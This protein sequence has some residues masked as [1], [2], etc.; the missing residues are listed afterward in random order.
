MK[1]FLAALAVLFALP[2]HAGI[3]TGR[4]G[5]FAT[6]EYSGADIECFNEAKFNAWIAEN[7]ADFLMVTRIPDQTHPDLGAVHIGIVANGKTP[8]EA[9][10]YYIMAYALSTAE[11]CLLVQGIRGADA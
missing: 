5:P 3:E 8:A 10:R 6:V 11:V 4:N 9:T 1:A 7:A 2:A